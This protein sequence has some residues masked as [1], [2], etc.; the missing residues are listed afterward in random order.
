MR[1]LLKIKCLILPICNDN[2]E[3]KHR[4]VYIYI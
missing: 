3:D 1:L 2:P 4:E